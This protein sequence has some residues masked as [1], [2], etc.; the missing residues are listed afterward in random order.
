MNY[1]KV[2]NGSLGHVQ[3]KFHQLSSHKVITTKR[4]FHF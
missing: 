4:K 1:T 2:G 3:I